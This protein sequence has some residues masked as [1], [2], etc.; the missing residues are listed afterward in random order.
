MLFCESANRLRRLKA[1]PRR[2]RKHWRWWAPWMPQLIHKLSQKLMMI[3]AYQLAD[4]LQFLMWNV[5]QTVPGY[6]STKSQKW[7]HF[8]GC[9]FIIPHVLQVLW[10]CVLFSLIAEH[11]LLVSMRISSDCSLTSS[12]GRRNWWC[13]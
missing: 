2:P 1:F 5:S 13:L 3:V 9:V 4:A 10:V 12:N 8:V 6:I 11:R 7:Q